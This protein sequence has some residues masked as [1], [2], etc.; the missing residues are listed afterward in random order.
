[1]YSDEERAMDGSCARAPS[2]NPPPGFVADAKLSTPI[3]RVGWGSLFRRLAPLSVDTDQN[4]NFSL[5]WAELRG[6]GW[7]RQFFS[8]CELSR[9]SCVCFWVVDTSTK[10]LLSAS[11][12]SLAMAVKNER[13]LST[14]SPLVWG[15]ERDRERDR[16]RSGVPAGGD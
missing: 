12:V 5:L 13:L 9:K 4:S 6:W 16:E 8:S 2:R 10:S 3:L 7:R 11:I 14:S 15:L 1:M